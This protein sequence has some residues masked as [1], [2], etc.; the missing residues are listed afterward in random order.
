MGPTA[1][2]SSVGSPAGSQRAS[3]A[4]DLLLS[5]IVPL[6]IGSANLPAILVECAAGGCAA[7]SVLALMAI[8][9]VLGFSERALVPFEERLLGSTKKA[10]A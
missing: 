3:S 7:S 6:T 8:A 5:N 10:D 4:R 1:A 9:M 2:G